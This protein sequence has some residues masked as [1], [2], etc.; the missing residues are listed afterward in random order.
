[1]INENP[2]PITELRVGNWIDCTF[3]QNYR[4]RAQILEIRKQDDPDNP[5]VISIKP[6]IGYSLNICY[7]IYITPAMLLRFGFKNLHGNL[8]TIATD[9]AYPVSVDFTEDGVKLWLGKRNVRNWRQ[10]EL[11]RLQNLCEDLAG[12]TLQLQPKPEEKECQC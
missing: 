2:I 11:H 8:Y 10:L 12:I 1:M 4:E 6:N 5:H 3:I 9:T 7:P